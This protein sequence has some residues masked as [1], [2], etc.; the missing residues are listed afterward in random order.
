MART[1]S[2][3]MPRQPVRKKSPLPAVLLLVWMAG[4][5]MAFVWIQV[6]NRKLRY[7]LEKEKSEVIQTRNRIRNLNAEVEKRTTKKFIDDKIELYGMALRE[8]NDQIYKVTH[9]DS[10]GNTPAQTLR[11]NR[12]P[13]VV[14][15]N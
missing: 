14:T 15:Q 2:R 13:E 4:L 11:G 1:N 12:D 5:A 9:F 10:E 8:H 6:E 7:S 3:K